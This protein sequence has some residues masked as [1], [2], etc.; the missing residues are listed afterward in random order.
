MPAEDRNSPPHGLYCPKCGS[1]DTR[2]A[3]SD[4]VLA[5]LAKIFGRYPF[6]CRSCRTKFYRVSDPPPEDR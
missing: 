2:R 5:L 6:R 3:R 4:G 1:M